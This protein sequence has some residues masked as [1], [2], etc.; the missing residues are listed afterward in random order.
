LALYRS[1]T[2]RLTIKKFLITLTA[3]AAI[4][5]GAIYVVLNP[6]R[7]VIKEVAQKA[8]KRLLPYEQELTKTPD[9]ATASQADTSPSTQPAASAE[10]AK[11]PTP[12]AEPAQQAAVEPAGAQPPAGSEQGGSQA[13]GVPPSEGTGDASATTPDDGTNPSEQAAVPP[14]DG[15]RPDDSQQPYNVTAAPPGAMPPGPY[16]APPSPNDSRPPYARS[17]RDPLYSGPPQDGPYGAPPPQDPYGAPPPPP[18]PYGDAPQGA[19]GNGPYAPG[20]NGPYGPGGNGPYGKGS[21]AAPQA[22]PGQPGGPQQGAPQEEWVVVLVSG[23]SMRA[24]AT[25]DAPMLFA[26]P[27]GRNLKV[28]SRYGDWVEVT[29]P[30]SAATGWMKNAEVSPIAPP[31]AGPAPTEAYDTQPPGDQ[32]GWFRRRRGGFADMINRALGGG[33]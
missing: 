32:G 3:L 20:G 7:P 23:A 30:K 10:S 5:C 8:P 11:A 33:F 21:A 9:Q 16:G 26:F 24:T 29:D 31:G 27:Y 15:A 6:P 25:E 28:V 18:G 4:L 19:Y 13:E 17:P 12:A 22:A 14:D 1:S 2:G